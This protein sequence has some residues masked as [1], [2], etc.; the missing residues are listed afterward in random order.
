[1]RWAEQLR[2][3]VGERN[4]ADL[5]RLPAIAYD[6]FDK[7]G[8]GQ[9][10]VACGIAAAITPHGSAIARCWSAAMSTRWSCAAEVRTRAY[11]QEDFVFDPL[12]IC[13]CAKDQSLIIGD[14]RRPSADC[15]CGSNRDNLIPRPTAAIRRWSGGIGFDAVKHLVLSDRETLAHQHYRRAPKWQHLGPRT[16]G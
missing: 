1:M 5:Q 7:C 10:A 2:Q 4:R 9:F 3:T 14:L 6:A 8:A 15:R 16:W 11:E 12:H 13:P